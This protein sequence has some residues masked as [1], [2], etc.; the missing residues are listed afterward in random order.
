MKILVIG[1]MHGNETLGL[2]VVQLFRNNPAINVD[3]ELANPLAIEQNSRFAGKDLNRSFPGNSG[4]ASYEDNRARQLLR[5]AQKY[6]LVLDFHNTFCPDNDCSF[7]GETA[8]NILYEASGYFGLPRVIVADYDCINKYAANCMSIEISM[9][10]PRNDPAIWYAL[11]T[12][13]ARV[14]TI[15]T[16]TP[17]EKYRFIYRMTL[18]D[19]ERLNLDSLPLAAF[20]PI[21]NNLADAMGIPSPAYPIFIADKFTPYNYG[22]L[23]A[24]IA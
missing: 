20:A 15:T 3:T 11:I 21:D 2:E 16:A 14:E 1:G 5:A 17:I 7:V 24:R 12:A 9:D 6:D 8:R 23:L 4:D 13:L 10:S 18:E 22:G 19:K